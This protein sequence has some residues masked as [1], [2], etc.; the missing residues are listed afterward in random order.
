MVFSMQAL[1]AMDVEALLGYGFD[2]SMCS[3]PAFPCKN[4]GGG[5]ERR[6]DETKLNKVGF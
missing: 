3:F 1:C 5:I 4:R 6:L 2:S